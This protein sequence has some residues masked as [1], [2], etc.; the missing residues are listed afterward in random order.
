MT[1]NAPLT[2]GAAQ[3]AA[4]GGDVAANVA[5]HVALIDA[6]GRHGVDVLVFPEL[7][8]TGYPAEQ[9]KEGPVESDADSRCRV[10]DPEG[11]ELAPIR[12]AC[13]RSGIVAV[14]GGAVRNTR[15]LG[16]SAIAIDRQ[17]TVTATYDKQH[18]DGPEKGWFVL[19]EAG[20]MIDVDGWRLGLGICYDSSF[21]EHARALALAGADAYLV[22]GAFPLGTSDRRREIYFPA[23]ALENTVYLAF[24]NYVGSHDG[25]DY[26]G[27]SAVY[28]PDGG[29]LADAGPSEAGIAVARLDPAAL[30]RSRETTQ[31]LADR[32]AVAPEVALAVAG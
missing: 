19:G 12:Q 14:V 20:C 4:V 24:S 30:G 25:F 18:L 17:G 10:V 11:A 32:R 13:R 29:V 23:R 28:G 6:A 31:M 7:S 1:D 15:G 22:S 2:V 5:E 3:F 8:V 21:P 26:G 27:R 9:M 16:L